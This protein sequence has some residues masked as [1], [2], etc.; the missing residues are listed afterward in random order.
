MGL[1]DDVLDNVGEPYKGGSKGFE[2]GTHE[3]IIGSVEPQQKKTQ[4]NPNA[5]VIVVTVFD[6]KD[7]DRTAE[8]TLYFHTAG[9]AKMS[10]TKV[11]GI[12]VHNVGEEKKDK[13]RELGR[14]L[15]ADI[16]DLTKARD[17]AAQLM[18]DKFM[19]DAKKPGYNAFLFADPQGKYKTTNYG[20]IWHYAYE[21]P[22]A[23]T[24]ADG[25]LDNA[26]PLSEEEKADMPDF[27]DL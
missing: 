16:D 8:A 17:V 7:Q 24:K 22:E 20:D 10:L 3:V 27:D 15:F 21:D 1:F 12:M 2:Y 13:V 11:L 18:M 23:D 5:E 14:K 6:V 9:G 4:S 19:G 26:T 25:L